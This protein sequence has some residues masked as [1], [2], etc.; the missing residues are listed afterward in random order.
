MEELGLALDPPVSH[1]NI[2]RLET[3]RSGLTLDYIQQIADVLGVSP[4]EIITET[5][6]SVYYAPVVAT[7]VAG[8]WQEA[9]ELT[10]S[11]PIPVPAGIAGPRAFLLKIDGDSMSDQAGDGG[12]ALV[13]PDDLDLVD[14]KQ[15]A[16]MNEHGE[17]TYKKFQVSPPA[18]IPMSGNPKHQPIIIGRSQ[19][20]VIGRVRMTLELTD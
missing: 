2:A 15:Y 13:D 4:V 6:A 11:E 9:V 19:F 7:I 12:Y 18:L 3:R 10:D 5:T 14:G 20:I 8:N 17:T 1:S 16:V